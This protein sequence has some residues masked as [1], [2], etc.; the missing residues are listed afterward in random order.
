MKQTTKYLIL[1]GIVFAGN[2]FGADDEFD[3]HWMKTNTY[4]KPFNSAYEHKSHTTISFLDGLGREIQTQAKINSH[5]N[6]GKYI[7]SGTYNDILGRDSITI[8]PYIGTTGGL[9]LPTK[10]FALISGANNYYNGTETYRPDAEGF[11]YFEK[12]YW[13]DGSIKETGK[14]GKDFSLDPVEGHHTKSWRFVIHLPSISYYKI[15]DEDLDEDGFIIKTKLNEIELD[16]KQNNYTFFKFVYGF[17]S[18]IDDMNKYEQLQFSNIKFIL[19][20][21]D[22]GVTYKNGDII[23]WDHEN[24]QWIL[25]YSPEDDDIVYV[26]SS[27]EYFQFDNNSDGDLKWESYN[28]YGYDSYYLQVSKDENDN[29]I[30]TINDKLGRTIKTCTDLEDKRLITQKKYDILGNILE[31][32]PPDHEIPNIMPDAYKTTIVYNTLGQVI[33]KRTPDAGTV[34]MRYERIGNLRYVKDSLHINEEKVSLNLECFVEYVYDRYNRL[35]AKIDVKIEND[36]QNELWFDKPFEDYPVENIIQHDTLI[37]NIYDEITLEELMLIAKDRKPELLQEIYK[38]LTNLKQRLVA[39]I[40]YN[41]HKKVI[42]LYSYN[43]QGQITSSYKIIYKVHAQ[44]DSVNYTFSGDVCEHFN[45]EEYEL[46]NGNDF[47]WK[48]TF[49]KKIAFDD[50]NR[51]TSFFVKSSESE[52]YKKVVE[53]FYTENGIRN[54]KSFFGKDDPNT[55][56]EDIAFTY[57]ISEGLNKIAT[58]KDPGLFKQEIFYNKTPQSGFSSQ[59]TPLYNYNISGIHITE[60]KNQSNYYSY[61]LTYLYDGLNRLKNVFQGTSSGGTEIFDE[62]FSY[63]NMGRITSKQEGPDNILSGYEYKLKTSQLQYI[64]NS[65]KDQ[66]AGGQPNYLYDPNGN[67]VC[68]RSKKMVIVYDAQNMPIW[69]KFYNTIPDRQFTWD[70]LKELDTMDDD[71]VENLAVVEMLYDASGNRVKKLLYDGE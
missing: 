26:E 50:D 41:D 34:E 66:T 33:K 3:A 52:D 28:L 1:I 68:D 65:S 59:F 17:I 54:K 53:Y 24:S 14:P 39:E 62:S 58:E 47:I 20:Y 71:G 37:K 10:E 15:L 25:D 48:L 60:K 19:I 44:K 56:I 29:Y 16:E 13:Q 31:T 38:G 12:H 11:A 61:N 64:P 9:F 45:Y 4:F 5:D 21:G 30:Q 57:N 55:S 35:I 70:T 36:N 51:A 49:S 63:D 46:D 32:I 67:M 18:E 42:D 6:E 27:H 2:V 7:I 22:D 23:F 43:N 40:A 8:K 69:F